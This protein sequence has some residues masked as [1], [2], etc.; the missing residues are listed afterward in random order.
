MFMINGK[1]AERITR[2]NNANVKNVSCFEFSHSKKNNSKSQ[3]PIMRKNKS[4]IV[5]EVTNL[6]DAPVNIWE[7]RNS[8]YNK[9]ERK[10][11]V[12]KEEKVVERADKEYRT[13]PQEKTKNVMKADNEETKVEP[14]IP[15]KTLSNNI[16]HEK[17]KTPVKIH[18]QEVATQIKE[19]SKNNEIRR[20]SMQNNTPM[21]PQ[22][23]NFYEQNSP[24]REENKQEE[25]N[26]TIVLDLRE[27]MLP[28]TLN[29]YQITDEYS[30]PIVNDAFERHLVR[31]ENEKFK[32]Y[33]T[34]YRRDMRIPPTER[35]EYEIQKE[36]MVKQKTD[37][38]NGV[39]IEF[40]GDPMQFVYRK[41]SKARRPMIDL[42]IQDTILKRKANECQEDAG[43]ILEIP[44]DQ[45][46]L[47][48]KN[49]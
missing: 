35:S 2:H 49:L 45:K 46:Y 44:P 34:N 38:T 19:S 21:K 20:F 10:R 47:K 23:I 6:E 7:Y 42:C 26:N 33:V 17:D 18:E 13:E 31:Q 9:E 24:P 43:S 28:E 4:F 11:K 27:E 8:R 5:K 15:P 39:T 3:E 41:K 29:Q 32:R 1:L 12:K 37:K 14:Q 48:I 40:S 22:R 30:N 25:D 36:I 16:Y